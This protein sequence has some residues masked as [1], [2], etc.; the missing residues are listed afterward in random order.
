M[1]A[2]PA[3]EISAMNAIYFEGCARGELRVRKCA[4][5]GALFRFAHEWCPT[6]WSQELGWQATAGRGTISHVSVVYQAPGPAFQAD[7]PYALVL[8]DLDE[9]VRMMSNVVD[10]PVEAVVIGK[11]V[12]VKFEQRGAVTLPMFVLDDGQVMSSRSDR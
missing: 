2:K 11:R 3:P 9:G 7:A 4:R 10:C 8:I 12:K 5:C 6:C 1:S